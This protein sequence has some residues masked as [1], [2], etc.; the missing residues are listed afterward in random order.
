MK[1][2]NVR[3]GVLLGL[4][5]TVFSAAAQADTLALTFTNAVQS[6]RY[7]DSV[8]FVGNLSITGVGASDTFL[9]GD[10]FPALAGLTYILDYNP[11]DPTQ[12]VVD[13]TDFFLILPFCMNPTGSPVSP[14]CGGSAPSSMTGVDLFTVSAGTSA[15]PGAYI[16]TFTILGGGINDTDV[17]ASADFEV[18]VF[19]PEPASSWL[20]AAGLFVP[21]W[22]RIRKIGVRALF[23]A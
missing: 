22:R 18:D 23:T 9:N 16:G 3:R 5:L 6:V 7:G 2:W 1:R 13:D 20:L 19:V 8:T 17:L 15:A 4:A 10:E 11:S 14:D 21:V 12:V